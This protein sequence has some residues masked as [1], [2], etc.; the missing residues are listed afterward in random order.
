MD[1]KGARRHME[2]GGSRGGGGRRRS[3]R[4]HRVIDDILVPRIVVDIYCD[5]A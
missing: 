4:A 1:D 2:A 5:A 3:R